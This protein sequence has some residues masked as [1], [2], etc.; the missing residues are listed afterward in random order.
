M[1][2]TWSGKGY[3][4][5]L[6]ASLST[7]GLMGLTSLLNISVQDEVITAIAAVVSGVFIW[8]LHYRLQNGAS[9]MTVVDDE[10]GET[11]EFKIKHDFCWFPLRFWGLMFAGFGIYTAV[12][13]AYP[14][15][16]A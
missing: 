9:S 7:L 11:G 4:V 1:F 5:P 15:L 6:S 8:T 3:M 14:G 10:T 13:I 16:L 12:E 2:F